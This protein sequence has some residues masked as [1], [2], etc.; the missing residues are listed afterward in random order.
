[1]EQDKIYLDNIEASVAVL[2]KLTEEWKELSRRQSSLE[3]LKEAL[4]SFR[5]KVVSV[6]CCLLF[7]FPFLGRGLSPTWG[8]S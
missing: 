2:R 1:M 6:F 7:R 8:V 4:K 5:Q 3:A